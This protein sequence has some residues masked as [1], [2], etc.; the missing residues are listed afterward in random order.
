MVDFLPP[1]VDVN[2]L[3][4]PQG[5]VDFRPPT[6]NSPPPPMVDVDFPFSPQGTSCLRLEGRPVLAVHSTMPFQRWHRQAFVRKTT[7]HDIELHGHLTQLQ[8]ASLGSRSIFDAGAVK[9]PFSRSR[10]GSYT[11]LARDICVIMAIC[12]DSVGAWTK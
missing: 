8:V 3:F 5:M 7:N 10:N 6:V 11:F 2:F 4:P 9:H 12:E 1:M